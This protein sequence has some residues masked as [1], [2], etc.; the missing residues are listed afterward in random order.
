M[1]QK[2]KSIQKYINYSDLNKKFSLKVLFST[3]KNTP[4]NKEF[5]INLVLIVAAY[6]AMG[7]FASYLLYRFGAD[8][9]WYLPV[10]IT[11]MAILTLGLIQEYTK[12]K[13]IELFA[14]KNG[15]KY[16][17]SYVSYTE[18]GLPFEQFDNK[19]SSLNNVI[20]GEVSGYKFYLGNYKY[21]NSKVTLKNYK[22]GLI[23]IDLKKEL[24]TIYINSKINDGNVYGQLIT[25]GL[26]GYKRSQKFDLEGDFNNYFNVYAP[27][28]YQRDALYVLTPELMAHIVDYAKDFD[29]EIVDN[30][31][32]LYRPNR[33]IEYKE[34]DLDYIFTIIMYFGKEFTQNTKRYKDDRKNL[35]D[36]LHKIKRKLEKRFYA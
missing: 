28:D 4:K 11:L 32:K 23:A 26:G 2:N 35:D 1:T 30:Y 22:F 21:E 10:I 6:I 7:L 25:G 8:W 13:R 9:Y 24:P 20:S 18:N 29:L 5:Y 3:V 17:S 12:D 36:E 19:N 16:V 34:T 33:L 31:L 14:H 15:F 27:K